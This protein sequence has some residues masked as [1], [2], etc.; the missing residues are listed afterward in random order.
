MLI[1]LFFVDMLAMAL[2]ARTR[3]R[4]IALAVSNQ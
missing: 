2:L 3:P 4:I 1:H